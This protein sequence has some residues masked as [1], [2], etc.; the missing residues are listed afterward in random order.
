MRRVMIIG[1][2]GS[3][4]SSLIKALTDD[5][6]QVTKTQSLVYLNGLIDTP[7]EYAENPLF[8]R[9]LMA[10]S[11]QAAAVLLVQD[12]TRDRCGFPPGFAQGF[13]IPAVGAITKADHPSAN[14]DRALQLLRQVLH[15]S[16]IILT[17]SHANIGIDELR[18]LLERFTQNK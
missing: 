18:A 6:K 1:M 3:G 2:I 7:G 13:P 14:A 9:S 5:A 10:T 8:Y 17:S 15:A 4:K 11:H 16:E 12:A